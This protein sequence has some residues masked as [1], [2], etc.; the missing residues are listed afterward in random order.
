MEAIGAFFG[1]GIFVLN[2]VLLVWTSQD[3]TKRGKSGVGWGFAVFFL[4]VFGWLL[5]LL[6][7]PPL[8]VDAG[9]TPRQSVKRSLPRGFKGELIGPGLVGSG[10]LLP[11]AGGLAAANGHDEAVGIIILGLIVLV[12]GLVFILPLKTTYVYYCPSC[13]HEVHRSSRPGVRSTIGSNCE[14]CG[15]TFWN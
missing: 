5:W 6:T 3:A 12:V 11:V 2:V 9:V 13:G 1:V 14:R 4:G 7:R 8:G 15:T 10:I